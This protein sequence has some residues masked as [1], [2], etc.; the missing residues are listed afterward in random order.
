TSPA[1]ST[2]AVTCSFHPCV[3][4]SFWTLRLYL[5]FRSE[6]VIGRYRLVSFAHTFSSLRIRLNPCGSR[7]ISFAPSYHSLEL[8]YQYIRERYGL[9]WNKHYCLC[10]FDESKG[11]EH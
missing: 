3:G 4:S 7:P 9:C 1:D 8:T 5:Q 11:T 6:T 2:V 10:S